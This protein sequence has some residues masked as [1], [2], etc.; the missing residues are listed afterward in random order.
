MDKI[1]NDII[2]LIRKFA[3]EAGKDNIAIDSIFLFG[4]RVNGNSNEYS[5]IDI[6]VISDDFE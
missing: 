4:S 3:I 5:D 2:N 6:A 1:P